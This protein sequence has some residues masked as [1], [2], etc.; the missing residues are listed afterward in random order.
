MKGDVLAAGTA[1]HMYMLLMAMPMQTQASQGSG[2]KVCE[3]SGLIDTSQVTKSATVQLLAVGIS[4]VKLSALAA[5]SRP[6]SMVESAYLGLTEHGPTKPVVLPG[7]LTVN[8]MK[9]YE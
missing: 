6:E 3:Q 5:L 7:T 9:E 8:A 2:P 1:L 4:S